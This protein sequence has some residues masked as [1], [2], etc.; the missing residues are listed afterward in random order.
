MVE[1]TRRYRKVIKNTSIWFA[2]CS[3][4]LTF[5]KL[6]ILLPGGFLA[7]LCL[8]FYKKIENMEMK[9]NTIIEH[10]QLHAISNSI[11]VSSFIGLLVIGFPQL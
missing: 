10:Q 6:M 2:Q 4:F 9:I 5:Q 8:N 1:F 3:N 7:L 11:Q